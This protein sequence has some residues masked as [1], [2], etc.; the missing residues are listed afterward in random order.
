MARQVGPSR[1]VERGLP[2]SGNIVLPRDRREKYGSGELINQL[3]AFV[4]CGWHLPTPEYRSCAIAPAAFEPERHSFRKLDLNGP[5]GMQWFELHR[6]DLIMDGR[7]VLRLNVYL[8]RD[9]DFTTIWYGLIDP[10]IAEARL[11]IGDDRDLDL[12]QLYETILFRGDIGDASFGASVLKAIRVTRM[13][14]ALLQLSDEHGLE[15][16]PLDVAR[17]GRETEA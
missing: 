4:L 16:Q 15:C 7:D 14:P 11:G 5:G 8:T 2:V 3:P 13:A 10:L 17:D 12:A 6:P 9:V 1:A